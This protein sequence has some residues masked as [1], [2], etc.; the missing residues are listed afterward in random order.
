MKINLTSS[1]VW[2][3][4]LNIS[5][6]CVST[7]KYKDLQARKAQEESLLRATNNLLETENQNL[8][9]KNGSLNE[10]LNRQNLLLVSLLN[11]KMDLERNLSIAEKDLKTMTEQAQ[12][13]QEGLSEELRKKE[14]ETIKRELQLNALQS[15]YESYR[16][17]LTELS[18]Q[19][20]K[21]FESFKD[22]ELEWY[23]EYLRLDIVLYRDF[24][25]GT[26][27]PL[28]PKAQTALAVVA[29]IARQHP[30][31]QIWVEGHTDS[32]VT[33]YQESLQRSSSLAG[34]VSSH[35]LDHGGLTGSQIIT[36]AK[37]G[38][39]PRV[40]NETAAGRKLNNRVEISL[41]APF[42]AFA[43]L[44]KNL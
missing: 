26:S 4:V 19:L 37:S 35:L 14:E 9:K 22:S 6:S 10:D 17:L 43:E 12:Q 1:I 24:L 7:G 2:L 11:D 31:L 18:G 27:S 30:R 29:R 42:E 34:L 33:N 21:E 25:L 15:Q 16:T 41:I 38:H 32:S 8:E 36:S 39:Y 13:L 5:W 23:L 28:S 44:L 20:T 3:F 40:S